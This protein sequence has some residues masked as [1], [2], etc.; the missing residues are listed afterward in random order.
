MV[1]FLREQLWAAEMKE[2][3]VTKE[4]GTTAKG[5]FPQATEDFLEEVAELVADMCPAF[6][7]SGPFK[8]DFG[9]ILKPITQ[10]RV[11]Y[12]RLNSKNNNAFYQALFQDTFATIET[13]YHAH[14]EA[15]TIK[16]A[17]AQAANEAEARITGETPASLSGEA[18][19]AGADDDDE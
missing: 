5:D 3:E 11:I 18:D 9:Y 15:E 14:L 8:F 1:R 17:R 2:T 12:M 16:K 19:E 4:D 6:M 7:A 13:E 10:G